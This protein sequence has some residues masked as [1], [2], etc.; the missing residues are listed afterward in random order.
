M[1]YKCIRILTALWE[2]AQ[3]HRTDH[4]GAEKGHICNHNSYHVQPDRVGRFEL[5]YALGF[6]DWAW[7]VR[8]LFGKGHGAWVWAAWKGS[9]VC[10]CRRW[11]RGCW[12]CL[13]HHDALVPVLISKALVWPFVL[14]EHLSTRNEKDVKSKLWSRKVSVSFILEIYSQR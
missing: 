10:F 14:F 1:L 4:Q 8:E 6:Q 11:P 2:L 13:D 5:T 3:C 7:P 9:S 12:C